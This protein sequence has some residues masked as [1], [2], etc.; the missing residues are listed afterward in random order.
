MQGKSRPMDNAVVVMT[1]SGLWGSNFDYRP[2]ANFKSSNF[3]SFWSSPSSEWKLR[4]LTLFCVRKE[5]KDSVCFLK[6]Q[7]TST[8]FLSLYFSFI[9][10]NIVTLWLSVTW[11]LISKLFCMYFFVLSVAFSLTS[12][13]CCMSWRPP[14]SAVAVNKMT[15][16]GR[17]S[18]IIFGISL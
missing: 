17:T 9:V 13:Y 15:V 6:L 4:D 14:L 5:V 7:K 2:A 16:K 11:K 3:Y 10:F 1:T 18:F 12:N 8:G